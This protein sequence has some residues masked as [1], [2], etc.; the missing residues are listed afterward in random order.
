MDLSGGGLFRRDHNGAFAPVAVGSRDLDILGVLVAKAGEIVAK[1]ELVV[2]VWPSTVVEDSNLTVQISALRR[3]LDC[4]RTNGSCVQT[5]SGR[6]AEARRLSGD[7]R[8]S[9]L[10]R[11]QAVVGYWGVPRVRALFEATY[12]AGLRKA[13]VPEERLAHGGQSD[14]PGLAL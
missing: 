2:A 4:A 5:V 8:Y 10:A 6:L 13:G 11:L 1:E 3:L 9:S 12:F 7:D 14:R